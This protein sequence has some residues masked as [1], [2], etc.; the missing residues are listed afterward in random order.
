LAKANANRANTPWIFILGH[1]MFFFSFKAKLFFA[2]LAYTFALS[3]PLGPMYSS[4]LSTDSGPLQQYIEPLLKQ[5][6]VDL[7]MWGHMHCYERTYP[8]ITLF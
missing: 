5:Y 8:G 2:L 6:K 7:A 3:S 1:R 4:D